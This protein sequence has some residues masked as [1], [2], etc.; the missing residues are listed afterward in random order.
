MKIHAELSNRTIW[1]LLAARVELECGRTGRPVNGRIAELTP[2]LADSEIDGRWCL[3]D[4]VDLR[5]APS[6]PDRD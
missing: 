3:E 6:E 1:E 2:N 4:I 5:K